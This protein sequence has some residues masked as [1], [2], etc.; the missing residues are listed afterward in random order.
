MKHNKYPLEKK[1]SVGNIEL[2][3]RQ[4]KTSGRPILLLHGLA[5]NARIWDLVAPI[6]AEHYSVIAVDQRGHGK[7]AKPN[8][9]Y[10]FSTVT[11]DVITF[12][13]TVN[14]YN[15]IIVGHSW[16][17]SV[18]LCLATKYPERITGL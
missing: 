2:S 16:G 4:W 9:G 12:M 5:S 7:S 6:L 15:P 11:E 14:I 13:D 18:A 1:V 10:D 3:Y 8:E 17:G